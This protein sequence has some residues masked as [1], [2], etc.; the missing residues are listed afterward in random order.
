MT[1]TTLAAIFIF[2]PCI[3]RL[4]KH[5]TANLTSHIVKTALKYNANADCRL[6]LDQENTLIYKVMLRSRNIAL[7]TNISVIKLPVY[8][9]AAAIISQSSIFNTPKVCT[10]ENIRNPMKNM[11]TTY[12]AT[13]DANL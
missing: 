8:A 2:R 11:A 6:A 12:S 7:Q 4:I 1:N 9:T 5:H 13:H 10:R 3:N